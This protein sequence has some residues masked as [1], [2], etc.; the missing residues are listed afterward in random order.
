MAPPSMI[1]SAAIMVEALMDFILLW[2][3]TP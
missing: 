2:I 3:F 1:A